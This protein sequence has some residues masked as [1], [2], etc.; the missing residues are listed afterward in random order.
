MPE[1]IRAG[2]LTYYNETVRRLGKDP[3]TILADVGL[4]PTAIDVADVY[5]PFAKYLQLL[6]RTAEVTGCARFG[7]LLAKRLGPEA[8]GVVGYLMQQ[9]TNVGEAVQALAN[10]FHLHDQHG[11]IQLEARGD[12]L[13]IGY[14]MH[15]PE[16]PGAEQGIDV[17]AVLGHNVLVA[18]IGSDHQAIGYE[19][20][21]SRPR[22]LSPYRI[23]NTRKLVF[24][25]DSYGILIQRRDASAAITTA[26]PRMQQLLHDYLTMKGNPAGPELSSSVESL[27]SD[28]LSTGR[29]NLAAVSELMAMSPRTLQY[30][31]RREGTS[32]HAIVEQ[33]RKRQAAHYLRHSDI[34]LTNVALLLGYSDSTAFS[35][36]FRRWFHVTPSQ[37]RIQAQRS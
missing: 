15:D 1:L 29:C 37:W 22:D 11:R 8:L 10:F 36:S 4:E 25:A 30:K 34:D 32:L 3:G 13:R 23:L 24:D 28:L 33:V 35:R 20:P 26:D 18:L 6:G 16:Q 9:A 19:F 12:S 31:L 17:A 2:L 5:I 7:L 21:Y 27:V 14:H